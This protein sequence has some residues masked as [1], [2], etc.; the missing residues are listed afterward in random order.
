MTNRTYLLG[1]DGGGSKT[2]AML[3]CRETGERHRLTGG[4][5]NAITDGKAVA[6]RQLLEL[7]D[8][9]GQLLL[10]YNGRLSSAVIATACHIGSADSSHWSIQALVD[11]FPGARVIGCE[12]TEVALYGALAGEPG[13]LVIAGTGSAAVALGTDGHIVSCGGW[14]PWFGDE[15][16]GYWIGCEA[17]RSAARAADGRGP[18][19]MLRQLLAERLGIRRFAMREV[20][21]EIYGAGWSRKEIASLTRPVAEAAARSDMVALSILQRA[22]DWLAEHASTLHDRLTGRTPAVASYAGGAFAIG[23][24]L[25]GPLRER[26]AASRIRLVPPLL[27]PVEGALELARKE[28]NEKEERSAT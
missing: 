12:D 14:G 26:L 8:R 11:R 10:E 21:E 13:I 19:T 18:E 3:E 7:S 23:E 4:P 5:L 28:A 6:L 25:I 9:I 1:I 16:S 22:A 20:A 24:L 17:L 2:D 15:G 27:S